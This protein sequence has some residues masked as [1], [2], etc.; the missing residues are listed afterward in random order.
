LTE[1]KLHPQYLKLLT[2]VVFYDSY[3]Y[4]RG[5]SGS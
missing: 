2:V 4:Y 5:V 1:K 3:M